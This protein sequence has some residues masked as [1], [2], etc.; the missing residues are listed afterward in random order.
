[1]VWALGHSLS[2]ADLSHSGKIN[3]PVLLSEADEQGRFL[4]DPKDYKRSICPIIDEIEQGDVDAVLERDH[5]RG[6]RPGPLRLGS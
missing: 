2:Y 1:M 5:G 3:W 4:A 6:E